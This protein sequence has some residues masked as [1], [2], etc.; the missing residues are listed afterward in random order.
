MSIS[1][2]KAQSIRV[3]IVRDAHQKILKG[4]E[5]EKRIKKQ[6]EEDGISSN[7]LQLMLQISFQIE[8]VIKLL[9]YY[10]NVEK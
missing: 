2:S 7:F 8:T 1:C 5:K 10:N 9:M 3:E 6:N 4:V